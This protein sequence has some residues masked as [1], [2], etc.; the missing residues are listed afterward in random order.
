VK[1]FFSKLL[2]EQARPIHR[3][4]AVKVIKAGMDTAQVVARFDAERQALAL[5]DHPAIP[6]VY[7]G[8]VTPQGRPYFVMEFVR[9]VPITT[10]CSKPSQ[11]PVASGV[12]TIRKRSSPLLMLRQSSFIWVVIAMQRKRT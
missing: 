10:C 8:G 11:P 5:M 2:A 12:P 1:R 3:Q 9:G 7:D 6:R 4:V